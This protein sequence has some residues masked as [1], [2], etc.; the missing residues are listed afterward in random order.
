MAPWLAVLISAAAASAGWR[1]G[2]LTG[3]GAGAALFVGALVL[4]GTGWPGAAALGAF[5]VS[6]SAISRLAPERSAEAKGA[7]RDPRQVLANGGGAALGGAFGLADPSLGLWV[8]TASLAT[9]ASDTWATSFGGWSRT[10][11]RHVLTGESV[12]PG[13]NGGVTAL[14]TAGGLLGALFVAAAGGAAGSVPLLLPA[15][16]LVGFTG[17]LADSLLG[18]GVQG[19]F[20]CPRC[21]APSEWRIHR[22]GSFTVP[23]GGWAWLDNDGVNA[24]ATGLG[25]LGGWG[26]WV[27]LS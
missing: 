22:C 16:G 15:A 12:A 25:A 8:V 6:S 7:R 18:A 24:A 4:L 13:T 10:L 17:M 5:F 26:A 19:R 9:A 20:R 14:G 11:P 1:T 21:D 3:P 2:A 27:L 23:Q